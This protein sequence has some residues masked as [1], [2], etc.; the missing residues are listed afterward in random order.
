MAPPLS[1]PTARIQKDTSGSNQRT[2]FPYSGL[3]RV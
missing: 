1:R 2:D 3:Q